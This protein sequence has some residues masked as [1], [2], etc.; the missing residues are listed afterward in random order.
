MGVTEQFQPLTMGQI[1]SDTLC[2][3]RQEKQGAQAS[4][5]AKNKVQ[6]FDFQPI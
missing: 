2:T 3:Q 4:I 6:Y 1:R 5:K